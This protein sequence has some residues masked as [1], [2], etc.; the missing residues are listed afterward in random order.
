MI[1]LIVDG[2]NVVGSRPD[3]WWHDRPGAARRLAE[4]LVSADLTGL[5]GAPLTVHLVL[6]GKAKRALLP[7]APGFHIVL[8]E[9]DGDATIAALA[10][11]L[12]ADPV[13]VVTADRALRARVEAVGAGTTGPGS[14]LKLLGG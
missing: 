7:D 13:L 6:E 4:Q 10:A 12:A 14:L 2:A 8:A 11:E 5:T 3:G 1:H 9:A